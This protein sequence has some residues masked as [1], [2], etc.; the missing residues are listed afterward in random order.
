MIEGTEFALVCWCDGGA[1]RQLRANQEAKDMLLYCIKYLLF[2]YLDMLFAFLDSRVTH[3]VRFV[4]D[5]YRFE[6]TIKLL[7]GFCSL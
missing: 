2:E 5:S 1:C 6:V 7:V 4:F 3:L